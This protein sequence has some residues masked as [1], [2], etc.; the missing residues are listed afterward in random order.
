MARIA[1]TSRQKLSFL[2]FILIGSFILYLD[3]TTNSFQNVKNG[4]KALKISTYYLG[5]EY[6][7][8]PIKFFIKFS[9][10][11]NDLINENENLKKALDLSYLNN[12]LISNENIFYKDK[13]IIKTYADYKFSSSYNIAKLKN[14]DPNMY[15]CCDR[16]RMILEII[17]SNNY[18]FIESVVFNDQG[19]VGHIIDENIFFEVLLLTDTSHSLP[20]KSEPKRISI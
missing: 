5:R 1:P 3:V 4:F 11:K 9:K 10:N 17:E 18:D 14:I 19:I 15:K 7:I 8:E 16:H 13:E 2:I 12:Y 6:T 20:I